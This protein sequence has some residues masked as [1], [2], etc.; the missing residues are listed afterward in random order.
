MSIT[1]GHARRLSA[2][3]LEGVGLSPENAETSARCIVLADC[4]GV[5]SHGLLRLPYYL[6][7]SLAG[8]Y[9][10]DAPV[11]T[12]TDTGPV[13]VVDGGGGLGHWQLWTAAELAAERAAQYG[14]AAAAVGN[15]GHCGALGVYTLPALRRDM[16]AL[17]FS[18]GPAVMPAWGSAS[19]LF[20]TSPLAAGIP[21]APRPAIVDMATSAVARGKIAG[22]AQRGEPLPA[23]WA[24]DSAGEPTE[25]PAAALRGLLSPLGGAKGYALAFMVEALSAGL[26]GPMLSADVSDMFAPEEASRPQQIAHLVVVLDPRRLDVEGGEG[27]GRRLDDLAARVEAAGGRI[28]GSRRELPQDIPDDRELQIPPAL[29]G[30]LRSWS[31]RLGVA[32]EPAGE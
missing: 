30:E 22:Y 27:A 1:V 3:L 32:F 28:P 24:L 11:R 2:Q 12:V 23:G 17:T 16:V 26:V 18:H 29:E 6:D 7:R 14:I 8:G 9:P 25:D 21:C 13:V 19:A 31:E 5:G 4:W 15:S 20:S 10:P